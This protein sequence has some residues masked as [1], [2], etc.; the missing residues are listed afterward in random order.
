MV[1]FPSPA[2]VGVIAETR[3]NLPAGRSASAA[4]SASRRTLALSR[5]YGSRCSGAIFSSR[6]SSVIGRSEAGCSIV[7]RHACLTLQA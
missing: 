4:C 3:I 1:V 2:G 5:P 7:L 6:A